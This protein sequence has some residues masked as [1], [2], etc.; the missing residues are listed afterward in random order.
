LD[1]S[2]EYHYA[3]NGD[4]RTGLPD[5][6][7]FSTCAGGFVMLHK[8]SFSLSHTRLI[9][10]RFGF[11]LPTV[12]IA[13]LAIALPAKAQVVFGNGASYPA[14]SSPF[15]I[16]S[17]DFNGDGLADL[18]VADHGSIS[19]PGHTVSVLL[20]KPDGTFTPAVSFE[21]NVSPVY[22]SAGDFNRD[23]KIDIA[24][25]SSDSHSISV[26]TGRGDGTFN[27][28]VNYPTGPGSVGPLTVADFNRDGSQDLAFVANNSLNIMVQIPGGGF[29]P[30]A[31]FPTTPGSADIVSGDVN[32]DGKLD[33]VMSSG[34]A[35]AVSVMLGNGDGTFGPP[36][37]SSAGFNPIPDSIALG[38][39]NRD[40]KIDV[41][42]AFLAPP[43]V[44]IMLGNGSGSFALPSFSSGSINTPADLKVG[45]FNGDGKLDVVTTG[46]FLGPHAD[47]MVGKGDGTLETSVPFGQ[48]PGAISA[49]VADF[50][51]DTRP[52]LAIVANGQ[53]SVVMINATP[54]RP[55]N[56]AYFVHQHYLDFLAREP[57]VSGFDFWTAHIDQCGN[58]PACL[59]DRR[60]GSSAAFMVESEFQQSGYFVYRLYKAAFGR[61][62][63]YREFVFDRKRVVGGP[64]LDA[65]KVALVDAFI[66]R[67]AFRAAFP[68]SL[69]NADFVNRL[70]DSAGLIPFSSERQAAIDAMNAGASRAFV[71]RNV[72]ENPS[73]VQREYNPAFV[74]M[75]YFA[76]LRRTE[77]AR[78]F[79][80]WLDILNQQPTNFRRMVCAFITS[81]EYQRRFTDN[82]T[83]SNAEC[84]GF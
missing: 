36:I 59:F 22:V 71:F 21:S 63:T 18:V 56:T 73:L 19:A 50:N 17:G 52:D 49:N 11:S 25:I 40:G 38:D 84:A 2:Q 32:R 3:L 57:D 80:F 10:I 43:S 33:L 20:G 54:G 61:R 8:R 66:Q 46:V 34:T 74:Q 69:S 77:D 45:D 67:D 58:D 7:T 44:N 24:S 37:T 41:A 26:L 28:P 39:F 48:G 65:S 14:G 64:Q 55:D 4:G 6:L 13:V 83:H 53:V 78:G 81:E 12:I 75:Q 30:A 5:S 1:E 15:G 62:P 70:F 76:Y 31:T 68:D 47:V 23:A 9:K 35:K 60:V 42:V 72:A 29:G 16:S 79:Q 27:P 82:I 51:G